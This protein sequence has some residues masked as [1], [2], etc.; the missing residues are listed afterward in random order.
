[1][2]E[3]DF[4]LDDEEQRPWPMPTVVTENTLS[5]ADVRAAG[6]T[7]ILDH[8]LS[9]QP[10]LT[11]AQIELVRR[12][13]AGQLGDVYRRA[14][15]TLATFTTGEA[16]DLG[17]AIDS[18]ESAWRVFALVAASIETAVRLVEANPGRI[19]TAAVPGQLQHRGL[20][21]HW[22]LPLESHP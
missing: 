2:T 17:E 12:A 3:A 9:L 5:F 19:E 20:R 16:I 7:G 14:K 6:L 18:L 10:G 13:H 15:A 1:M 22:P 4:E 21:R 11:V 8:L